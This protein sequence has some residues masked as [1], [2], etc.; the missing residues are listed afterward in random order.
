MQIQFVGATERVTGSCTWMKYTRTGIEF[1]IDCGMVQGEMSEGY[2]NN[3]NFPFSPRNLKFV[4]L[5][6]AHLDH[7]GLIPRLYKEGFKGKIICTNATARLAKEILIDSARQS[8]GLYSANDVN[9]IDFNSIDLRNDFKWAQPIVIDKDLLVYFQ[10]SAHILGSASIGLNWQ[11]NDSEKNS[12]LF[13]GDIGNNTKEN[14]FQPLLKYRQTPYETIE[15]IVIESTYGNREHNPDELSFHNRIKVLEQNIIETLV[16]NKGQLIIPTFSM[17]RTQEILFDLYYIFKIK[18]KNNPVKVLQNLK[19]GFKHEN[20]YKEYLSEIEGIDLDILNNLYEI[21]DKNQY[22]LKSEYKELKVKA[23]YP[24]EVVCDSPLAKKISSIYAEELC[25]KEYSDKDH[26]HK[27]PY[28]N[29]QMKTLLSIEDEEINE[30]MDNLYAND[31]FQVGMHS[32]KYLKEQ[33]INRNKNSIPTRPRIYLTSSGMCDN[34]PVIQHLERTLQDKKNTILLTGYQSKGTNGALLSEL[35]TMEESQK[36][37]SYIR[38]NN[39]ISV[40]K[41]EAKIAH[42]GGYFG[43]ADQKSLLEYLFTDK[44]DKQYTVPNIFLNH[45]NDL[46]RNALKDAIESH[47]Q[48]LQKKYKD[49]NLYGTNIQIPKLNQKFYNLDTQ[50]WVDN[51]SVKEISNVQTGLTLN[52]ISVAEMNK[53]QINLRLDADVLTEA[54]EVLNSLGLNFTD[55]VNIFANMVVINK[56]LPFK[57][58]LSTK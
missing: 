39:K 8:R 30:L 45:G 40:D 49:S 50:A 33:E 54:K 5:T 27:Y 23:M 12:I 16:D 55:A 10:R 35:Q 36:S 52:D 57:V 18:W 21:N 25:R 32:I 51:I 58:K 20:E 6:H 48:T 28:R 2:E 22:I 56:G 47:S 29:E 3:K 34:G 9:K 14:S 26:V 13:T 24:I 17:H 46:A 7:C 43:H 4:F 19:H 38:L 41:V 1:L 42:I 37:N 11:K 53:V 44:D 31:K 15:N